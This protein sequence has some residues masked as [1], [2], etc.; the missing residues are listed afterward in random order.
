MDGDAA[1]VAL[2]A[3]RADSTDP[4]IRW[5]VASSLQRS[6]PAVI[7]SVGPK[8]LNDPVLA[9]RLATVTAM[10]PL[11]LELLPQAS[12]ADLQRGAEEFVAAQLVNSER[13]ESHIN[14]GNLRAGQR[15]FEEAEKAYRT[16]LRLNPQFVPAYVNLA[17]LYRALG[18]DIEGE[19]L[20]RTALEGIPS[21][22]QSALR[23]S[24]GLTLVRLG[25]LPEA[26]KELGLAANAADADP[27]YVLAYALALDAQ[28][29]SAA[30]AEVLEGALQ[31][32]GEYP[33]LVAT[34]INVYQRMGDEQAASA[35]AARIRN[36]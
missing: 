13:A 6:H 35:L 34:L 4:L 27:Q 21:D 23:Q 31:R 17:D 18:R 33:Q 7:G 1:T 5:A 11:D 30:A 16:A 24:L 19:E 10:A 26:I 22:S 3:E 29:E 2:V 15:R 9:V 25:R 12:I 20:L 8:L 28:G 36:R 14:I 32:F